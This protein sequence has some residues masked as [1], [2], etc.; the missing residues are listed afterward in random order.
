MNEDQEYQYTKRTQKD[1]SYSFKL[2][3]V[4]EVERGEIGIT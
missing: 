2:Q 4:D 3:V 1:Y